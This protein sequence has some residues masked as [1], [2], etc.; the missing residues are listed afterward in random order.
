MKKKREGQPR[1]LL[2][3]LLG[4]DNPTFVSD[5]LWMAVLTYIT[6]KAIRKKQEELDSRASVFGKGFAMFAR[7]INNLVTGKKEELEADP[8]QPTQ[9]IAT[10]LSSLSVATEFSLPLVR[11]MLNGQSGPAFEFLK[12]SLYSKQDIQLRQKLTDPKELRLKRIQKL[13]KAQGEHLIGIYVLK[14]VAKSGL[15]DQHSLHIRL[16][17]RD[18]R[19]ADRYILSSLSIPK[20]WM[21]ILHIQ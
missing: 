2:C 6:N 21:R 19:K 4:K 16:V 9:E 20:K 1:E 15:L 11:K 3:T 12:E 5:K 7:G 10:L 14:L 18:L 8:F 13:V 17:C